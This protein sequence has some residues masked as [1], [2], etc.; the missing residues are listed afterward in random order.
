MTLHPHK[1]H[2]PKQAMKYALLFVLIVAAMPMSAAPPAVQTLNVDSE[3][4]RVKRQLQ[5]IRSLP[6]TKEIKLQKQKTLLD[7]EIAGAKAKL[8]DAD[9]K[10]AGKQETETAAAR[11][12][13][14]AARDSIQK[15]LDILR[16]MNPQI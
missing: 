4:A 2:N 6:D 11:D 15:F 10:G 9:T 16:S 13:R 12:R 3:V 8:R 14:R 1:P 7:R 5:E